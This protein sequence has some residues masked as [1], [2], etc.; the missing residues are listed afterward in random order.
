MRRIEI[1]HFSDRHFWHGGYDKAEFN[2][3]REMDLRKVGTALAEA[4]DKIVL[5]A[6]RNQGQFESVS[7]ALNDLATQIQSVRDSANP[8]A[9]TAAN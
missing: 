3:L 4:H 5:A 2:A 1:A 6:W 9:A 8:P 7:K